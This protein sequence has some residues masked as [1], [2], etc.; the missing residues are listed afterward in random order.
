MHQL[1]RHGELARV[2]IEVATDPRRQRHTAVAAACRPAESSAW[3]SCAPAS[4]LQQGL[5]TIFDVA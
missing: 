3:R 4:D 5:Q 2:F 1:D